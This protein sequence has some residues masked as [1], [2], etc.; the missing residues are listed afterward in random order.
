MSSQHVKHYIFLDYQHVSRT[1]Q[2]AEL[3]KLL[4]PMIGGSAKM[5][6]RLSWNVFDF[7]IITLSLGHMEKMDT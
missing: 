2:Y 6:C 4:V 7:I 3:G 5:L 1:W